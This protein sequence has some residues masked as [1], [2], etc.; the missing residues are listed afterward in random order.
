[1]AD[2]L[3][4]NQFSIFNSP[5]VFWHDF[6]NK[7]ISIGPSPLLVAKVFAQSVDTTPS[8]LGSQP[9]LQYFEIISNLN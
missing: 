3:R 4:V 7:A 9:W 1:L 6:K 8:G 2:F 5:A